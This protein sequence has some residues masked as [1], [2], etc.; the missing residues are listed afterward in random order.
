MAF[1]RMV[2]KIPLLVLAFASAGLAACAGSLADLDRDVAEMIR[3]RQ[4]RNLGPHSLGDGEWNL[5]ANPP[6]YPRSIYADDPPTRNP[7][8]SLLPASANTPTL[9]P[10][11]P[12]TDAEGGP[13]PRAG[14]TAELDGD[15]DAPQPPTPPLALDLDGLLHYAIL[16]SPDYRTE[17]ESLF[18]AALGLVVERHLWGPRFFAAASSRVSGV[19]ESG[20]HALALSLLGELTASQRLPYGG[21]VAA[22]ALVD[23]V[24]LLRQRSGDGD[25]RDTQG[26]QLEASVNLPLLRG[27]GIVAREP[28]IQA[29]REVIYAAR[30]FERF[31]REFLV[32]I[33]NTYFN[34][35][36]LQQVIENQRRQ[37]D[38]LE[39][40]AERFDALAAA[41]RVPAF[42]AEQAQA[43]VLFGRSNLII[44]TES[45]ATAVDA[46]KLTLG[47]DTRTDLTLLPATIEIPVPD[48]DPTL[49]VRTA[50]A[51][52]LDLQT[53]RDL[54]DDAQRAV[55]VA[56]NNRLPD[57]DVT[58]RVRLPTDP[59]KDRAGFDLDAGEG[60]FSAGLSLNQE[61]FPVPEQVG[62]R[63]SLI[64][65]ERARRGYRLASDRVA[66]QVRRAIRDIEQARLRV[67]LQ[68]RNVQLA[69]RRAQG[70]ALRERELGPRDVIDAEDD[71][72]RAR[73]QRDTAIA[74][75]RQ[76]VL[77]YLLATGQIRV[78]PDGTWQVPP[79][80]E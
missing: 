75:L 12:T 9:T 46:F 69:E 3:Q 27:A 62:Y 55:A 52:R 43:Q 68:E 17:K 63:R 48:L 56:G 64:R 22:S 36:R 28:L 54:I 49:A 78:A 15:P 32:E 72:L 59:D 79:G 16:H 76:S 51:L 11:P 44:A 77:S 7:P 57:L 5:D 20:D 37:L 60:S 24:H 31:R 74:S 73:N 29:E 19:P 65:L 14:E 38:N 58:A 6:P 35:L 67:Q 10:T 80:L 30:D 4:A 53:T 34:L 47:M 1:R 21:T 23:Y 26:A 2:R 40:L 25:P 18:L 39:R 61:V 42:R 66:L 33:A 71:L 8:A 41:G 45:Y 50:L 70:V 13:S